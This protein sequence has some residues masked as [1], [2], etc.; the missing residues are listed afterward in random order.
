[1]TVCECGRMSGAARSGVC[2]KCMLDQA[3]SDL[4]A[5]DARSEQARQSTTPNASATIRDFYNRA[6]L[7]RQAPGA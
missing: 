2:T 6:V 7:P 3:I 4:R 1:M 5:L